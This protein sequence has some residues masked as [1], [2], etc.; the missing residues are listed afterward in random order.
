MER[1]FIYVLYKMLCRGSSLVTG[2]LIKLRETSRN[3]RLNSQ[4][5]GSAQD[6][7]ISIVSPVGVPRVGDQPVGSS[8]LHSPAQDANG[9]SSKHLSCHVLVHS[10]L[11]VDQ[12]LVHS[13]CA[14]H[15]SIGHDLVLDLGNVFAHRVRRLAEFLVITVF[16]LVTVLALLV[17][18]GS[19]SLGGIAGRACSIHVVLTRLNFI[20]STSLFRSICTATD[21]ALACPVGPGRARKSS[22]TSESA[23]VATRDQI[24]GREMEIERLIRVNAITVG[25]RFNG[26]KRPARSTRALVTDLADGGAVGPL[27]ARIKV[28][29]KV[30]ESHV[31][32]QLGWQTEAFRVTVDTHQSLQVFKGGVR[33]EV[34]TSLEKRRRVHMTC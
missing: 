21:Q 27:L 33:V 12:I 23:G 4:V 2:P 22:I 19:L 6:L 8:S 32:L 34:L 15:G 18:L 26:T 14:L 31:A 13:E 28:L 25:H 3:L 7:E 5:V 17:A 20:G 11:V 30:G 24:V 16:D 9:M 29:G 10:R 1:H